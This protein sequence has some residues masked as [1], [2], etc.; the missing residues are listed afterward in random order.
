MSNITQPF[1]AL[2][3]I[4]SLILSP[5]LL[6][7]SIPMGLDITGSLTNS[8]DDDFDAKTVLSSSTVAGTSNSTALALGGSL[9]ASFSDT[10]D[11][12][13]FNGNITGNGTDGIAYPFTGHLYL[14]DLLINM[15]NTSANDYRIIWDFT[16]AFR[17]DAEGFD[18]FASSEMTFSD[19]LNP[20][21]SQLF[22]SDL[23]LGDQVNNAFPPTSGDNLTASGTSSFT[24]DLL[25][26]NSLSIDGALGI[27]GGAFDP[28]S[29]FLADLSA[30]FRIRSIEQLNTTPPNP[31][32]IPEPFS[33]GL[34]ALG[35]LMIG[36][37]KFR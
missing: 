17:A 6:A 37:R 22:I 25:A 14:L 3:I 31:N 35:L 32:P 29:A 26:G 1:K 2:V 13:G 4:A 5:N 8:Q 15:D 10:G 19:S 33:L 36:K 11:G 20:L 28:D 24:F 23:A 27:G 9:T 21:F 16:Y 12:I 18:A 30:Q 34:M 7:A